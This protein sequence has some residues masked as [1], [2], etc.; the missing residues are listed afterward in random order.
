MVFLWNNERVLTEVLELSRLLIAKQLDMNE[1]S[2]T[3]SVKIDEGRVVPTFGVQDDDINPERFN[4]IASKIWE[5]LRIKL[6]DNL[7]TLD[8]RH[9][10]RQQ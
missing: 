1:N 10:C 6:S 3:V 2:V 4:T 7:K 5:R 8:V 9:G